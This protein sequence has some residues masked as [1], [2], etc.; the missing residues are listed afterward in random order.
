MVNNVKLE[1]AI[2]IAAENIAE[3]Y[4]KIEENKDPA[5]NDTYERELVVAFDDK[6][7]VARG[8]IQ[9][10]EKILNERRLRNEGK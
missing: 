8:E 6:E 3:I 4:K 10:I 2:Q 5:M 9:I 1:I 7:R